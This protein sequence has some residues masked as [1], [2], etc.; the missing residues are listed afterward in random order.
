M[1]NL[2][3][4]IGVLE[5]YKLH[6][7]VV[8]ILKNNVRFYKSGKIKET[9]IHSSEWFEDYDLEFKINTDSIDYHSS[10]NIYVIDNKLKMM[11]FAF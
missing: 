7:R 4:E 11:R 5:S 3:N 8:S 9:E 6:Q 1:I 2:E 10:F